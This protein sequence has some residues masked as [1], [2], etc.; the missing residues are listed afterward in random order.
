MRFNSSSLFVNTG[1]KPLSAMQ[2]KKHSKHNIFLS[3][4][5]AIIAVL[6]IFVGL[7]ARV[8]INYNDNTTH[9]VNTKVVNSET[10]NTKTAE[11]TN[12]AKEK[13]TAKA[14]KED[15]EKKEKTKKKTTKK[16]AKKTTQKYSSEGTESEY[17][18]ALDKYFENLGGTYAYGFSFI[19]GTQKYIKNTEK[20]SN[21]TA[22]SAFLAEYICAKIYTGE[23][24]YDTNV[25]GQSG[26]TL[27]DNLIRNGST[28]AANT[29]INHF[30]VEKLNAYMTAN[31]YTSTHFGGTI[32]DTNENGNYTSINDMMSLIK[33]LYDK[34]NVFPYSDLYKRMRQCRVNSRIRNNLPY[35]TTVAN[36]SLAN[37][38]EMFDAAIVYAPS[39]NYIFVATAN[40][41]GDDG[42]AAN[43]AIAG[44]ARALFDKFSN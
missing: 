37:S 2:K 40:G 25:G 16:T 41:F 14:K 18:K 34:S 36:I 22:V 27:I 35:E 42:T 15:E 21:S 5:I 17:S 43:T 29:L 6:C 26:N 10:A 11:K 7:I 33:K 44:G 31:G 8:W 32:T 20:I 9:E 3:L 23:F 13:E 24:D 1:R 28:D 38:K 4:C 12:P 19:D 30:T 39:G